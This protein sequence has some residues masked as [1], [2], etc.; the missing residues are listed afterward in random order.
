MRKNIISI[1]MLVIILLVSFGCEL[2]VSKYSVTFKSEFH[3]DVVVEVDKGLMVSKPEDL[4]QEGHIFMGWYLGDN[5]YN[6][7]SSVS[8]DITIKAKWDKEKY[9]VKLYDG[10]TLLNEVTC[11]YGDSLSVLESYAI[12]EGYQ[13]VSWKYNDELLNSDYVIKSDLELYGYWEE[14]VYAVKFFDGDQLVN[15]QSLGY[16][17]YASEYT[18]EKEGYN[19]LGWYLNDDLYDFN[20]LPTNDLNL[21]AKWEEITYTV[22]FVCNDETILEKVYSYNEELNLPEANEVKGYTFVKW[23]TDVVNVK[24]DLVINAVYETIIYNIKYMNCDGATNTNVKEYTVVDEVIFVN[25]KMKG[26]KFNGWFTDELFTTEIT[27]IEAGSTGDVT[28]YAMFEKVNEVKVTYDVNGGEFTEEQMSL[29]GED[30]TVT[31]SFNITEYNSYFWDLYSDNIF[32]YDVVSEPGAIYSLRVGLKLVDGRYEVGNKYLSG[33]NSYEVNFKGHAYVIVVSSHYEEA[34]NKLNELLIPGIK[35]TLDDFDT[36]NNEERSVNITSE[37]Y[38]LGDSETSGNFIEGEE[39]L[40]PTRKGYRLIGWYDENNVKYETVPSTSVTLIARWVREIGTPEEELDI[41]EDNLL[42]MFDDVITKDLELPVFVEEVNATIVWSSSNESVISN[43]GKVIKVSG[44]ETIVTLKATITFNGVV[45]EVSIDVKVAMGYK[46]LSK[47]GIIGGYNYTSNF[48]DDETLKNVDILYCAFGEVG[49]NGKISN[50]SSILSNTRNYID[51]AHS[52]GT[53]VLISI[54][55]SNLATV[56]KSDELIEVFA[57]DLVKLIN[58]C[59]LDGID[60]DWETPTQ[61]TSTNYTRLMKVVREKVKS[62]NPSHLVTSAL[63]AG[64]WQYVKFDLANSHKYLDYINLMS[65]DMQ[66]NAKSSYQN[67]LYK[68]SKGYTLTQCSI[69]QTLPLYNALGVPNEKIIIGV[70]FYARVFKNTNGLGEA[71]EADGSATQS[72]L[73]ENFLSKSVPGVTVGWD[74]ECKVPYIYDANNK[75]FYSY[76]NEKSIGIKA[77]YIHDKGLAGMMYWQ[78]TQDYNNK[79]LNAIYANKQ[80]MENK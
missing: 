49:A 63:G 6:F 79:L 67:A 26:H 8:E 70:P 44:K 31:G 25:P 51:K 15:E 57:N 45:R 41:I 58:E 16:G 59:K 74:D 55:T 32:L 53:Y 40:V 78:R 18:L 34:Y 33:T 62:N 29:F 43:D 11:E 12:K 4:K 52:Y 54:S 77:E 5:E 56:A 23:D 7:E 61:A 14:I 3:D 20:S 50:Y 46:D 28:I 76:E 37:T 64:P 36:K 47:G 39:L 10:N 24:S 73:Y 42:T 27:K 72:Y 30:I 80:T 69:D 66:T 71:S 35:L 22:K 13:L 19:F 17:E 2:G 9:N 68:S 48:P 38:I 1:F 60:M 65:Y 75:R 21:Y